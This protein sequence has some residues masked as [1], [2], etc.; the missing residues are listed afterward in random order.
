MKNQELITALV[1]GNFITDPEGGRILRE[2]ETTHREVEEII[3]ARNI[4][5]EEELTKLKSKILNIPF[6]RIDPES[7]PADVFKLMQTETARTY[8]MVPISKTND[9]LVVGMVHPDNPNAQEALRFLAKQARVNLGVYLMTPS[10]INAVLRKFSPFADEIQAAIKA[11][12]RK[13]GE[14]AA[15]QKLV[16]LEEGAQSGTNDAPVIKIVSSILQEAVNLEASDIHIEPQRSKTRIRFRLEGSLEEYLALPPELSQAVVARVKVLSNMRLDETRVPQ[17]GRFRTIVYEKEIDFRVSTFPT[18]NGEKV[19]LRVLDP[20]VGLKSLEE[21]GVVGKNYQLLTDSIAKPFGMILITGPTGSGKT[22]TLYALMQILNKEEVNIISLED[23]VEYTIEGVNQSQVHPEI[24]YDFA[25][26]LRQILRQDPD[27]LM[28]GEIRDGETASLAVHAALTGHIV[29]STLH[30]N[31][32][33]GVIPRL[34]DMGV[35]AFLISAS[36][37]AMAG[38]R[39]VSR[40]CGQCKTAEEASAQIQGIIAKSLSSLDEQTRSKYKAPY[41]IFRAKGCSVCKGKGII[42]RIALF[43]VF[44]MTPELTELVVAPDF[45]EGKLEEESRRQGMITLRQDGIMKALDGLVS[46][47]EVLR[48]TEEA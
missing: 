6:K 22:T 26:G 37:T 7:I 24:G 41:K 21:I 40:M 33:I 31:N 12:Q 44:K 9:L 23:P 13:P 28:V 46:I 32:A 30:T 11:V 43:E 1:Q 38:Q 3:Y 15:F 14:G 42:G 17:D 4:V 2:A 36:L 10:D 8:K 47:E 34:I 5:P 25:S 18:P 19:A 48:E 27:S 20:K 39:L 29:L 16:R 45:S 35:P